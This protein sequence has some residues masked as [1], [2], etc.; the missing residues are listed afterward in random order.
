MVTHTCRPTSQYAR[1]VILR[2][3]TTIR[4]RADVTQAQ[5]DEFMASLMLDS[6]LAL[7][8]GGKN[9]NNDDLRNGNAAPAAPAPAAG[10]SDKKKRSSFI[11]LLPSR[12]RP[13]SRRKTPGP[14]QSMKRC[15]HLVGQNNRFFKSLDFAERR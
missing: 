12:L 6:R 7:R 15:I 2:D 13:R 11:N 10:S 3:T 1:S 5:V 9:N 14:E 8:V 4:A